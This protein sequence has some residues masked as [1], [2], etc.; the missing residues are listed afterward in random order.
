MTPISSTKTHVQIHQ[1]DSLPNIVLVI[2][3]RERRVIIYGT[4]VV[5]GTTPWAEPSGLELGLET[6]LC[7][8]IVRKPLVIILHELEALAGIC[9]DQSAG[10]AIETVQ[11]DWKS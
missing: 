8:G 3:I 2:H 5:E 10:I 4:V 11:V 1:R 7:E 9:A 6:W